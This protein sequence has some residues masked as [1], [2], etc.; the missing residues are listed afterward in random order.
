MK[1][2]TIKMPDD[3]MD[4]IEPY[5]YKELKPFSSTYLAGYLAERYDMKADECVDRANIR[6]EYTA[7]TQVSAT[8]D[9]YH[10][11]TYN[12]GRF[13]MKDQKVKYV[14]MPVWMLSNQWDG[15]TYTFAMNGQTGKVTGR[16]PVDKGAFRN[17]WLQNSLISSVI[18]SLL[19][20]MI[21]Y[22]F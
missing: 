15:E 22:F 7:K 12:N 10:T 4:S 18:V 2:R 21:S 17:I 11:V 5:D 19:L 8:V 6:M 3:Y 14:L 1:K 13:R 16:L 20:L 9:G